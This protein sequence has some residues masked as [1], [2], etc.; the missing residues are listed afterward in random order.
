M[1]NIL[2]SAQNKMAHFRSFRFPIP[3]AAREQ[4]QGQSER[5]PGR[6]QE[7]GTGGGWQVVRSFYG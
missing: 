6:E 2:V 1:R 3:T 7:P 4:T 5:R